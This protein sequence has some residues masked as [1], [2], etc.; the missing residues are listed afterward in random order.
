MGSWWDLYEYS[1]RIV[2][3][4][5]WFAEEELSK[6]VRLLLVREGFGKMRSD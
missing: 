2:R 6:S 1:S 4:D 5:V 3:Q